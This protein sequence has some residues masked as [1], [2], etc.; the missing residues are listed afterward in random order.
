MKYVLVTARYPAATT[1]IMQA[2]ASVTYDTFEV[3]ELKGQEFVKLNQR[4]IWITEV[5][6]TIEPV[7]ATRTILETK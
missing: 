6:A 5:L 2:G 3:A 1:L 4:P 7:P